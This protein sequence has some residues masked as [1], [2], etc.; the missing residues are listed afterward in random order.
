MTY[1][2][3]YN[4]WGYV[5]PVVKDDDYIDIAR[6]SFRNSWALSY[7]ARDIKILS[8]NNG[9]VA[10]WLAYS[11]CSNRWTETRAAVNYN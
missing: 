8:I 11:S 3:P 1:D 9:D 7:A 2:P 10:C 4:P 6:N 5:T